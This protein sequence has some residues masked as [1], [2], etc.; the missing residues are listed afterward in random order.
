MK[1]IKLKKKCRKINQE[2]LKN[3][4]LLELET[5]KNNFSDKLKFI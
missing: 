5:I 1:L 3:E 2:K 4:Y